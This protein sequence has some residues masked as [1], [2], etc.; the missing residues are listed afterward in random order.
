MA[1]GGE[2]GLCE[3]KFA[4]RQ[5]HPCHLS[6]DYLRPTS[7]NGYCQHNICQFAIR[8]VKTP[9]IQPGTGFGGGTKKMLR[10]FVQ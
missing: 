3:P 4:V 8:T 6:A 7:T 1:R 9:R 2:V 5:T 10:Q